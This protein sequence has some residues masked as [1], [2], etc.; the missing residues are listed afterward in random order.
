M[1]IIRRIFHRMTFLRTEGFLC[2]NVYYERFACSE[3]SH[4]T[5]WRKQNDC[6][7]LGGSVVFGIYSVV[8]RS[9]E[10]AEKV[11]RRFFLRLTQV[12]TD[13]GNI[14]ISLSP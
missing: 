5:T 4:F 3:W 10:S 12:N 8:F 13:K 9:G 11:Q 6:H 1:T 7:S 2:G 14:K